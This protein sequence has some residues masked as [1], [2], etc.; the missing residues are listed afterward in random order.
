MDLAFDA[1]G[2]LYV[3]EFGN[4]SPGRGLVTRVTPAAGVEQDLCARYAGGTRSVVARGF[5]SPTSIAIGPDGALY[6][7]NFGGVAR[8]GQVIRI[9]R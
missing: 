7:T 6:V 4:N 2:D 8:V 3:I 9:S 5:T 1:A